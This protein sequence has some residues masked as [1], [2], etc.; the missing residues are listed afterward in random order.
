MRNYNENLCMAG[1][2]K[3]ETCGARMIASLIQSNTEVIIG[4]TDIF[5]KQLASNVE[6]ALWLNISTV[7]S[8]AVSKRIHIIYLSLAYLGQISTFSN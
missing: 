7:K 4:L 6:K 3:K 5:S 1:S 2:T 8:G